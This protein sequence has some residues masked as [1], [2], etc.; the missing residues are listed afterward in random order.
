MIEKLEREDFL[1]FVQNFTVTG[2]D[3]KTEDP[4]TELF[5]LLKVDSKPA[6]FN[7]PLIENLCFPELFPYGEGIK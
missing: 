2:I 1:D 4:Y 5:K 3:Q 7:D 6:A